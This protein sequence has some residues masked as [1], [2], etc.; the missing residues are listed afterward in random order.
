MTMHPMLSA[1]RRHKAGVTL[2]AMQIALTLA[3]ICNAIFII[4]Q[5]IGYIHQPT[6]MADEQQLF[7][8][9]QQW[10][11]A[12]S[13][14]DP[15][16]L[17]KLDSMQRADLAALRMLP[18]VASVTS[19]NALPM[20]GSGSNG[21]V[22]LKPL[23]DNCPLSWN[24]YYGDEQALSTMGLKLIAGRNFTAGEV[25]RSA[26]LN[27]PVVSF[28]IISQS[29]A[30][31]LFPQGDAVGKVVYKYDSSVPI[32]IV[33]VVARLQ[34]ARNLGDQDGAWDSALF[35]T[36][37]DYNATRYAVRAKPGRLEAAM[38]AVSP[39]L[40]AMNPQRV[41]ADD[42]VRAFTDFR[43]EAYRA[44]I[45]MAALMGGVCVILLA[46]TALGI[47][48]M[49]NFWVGERY[50]QI[51]VRRALG[52]RKV[53]ILRYFQIENL[54]I[55]GAG[56][57]IGLVMAVALNLVLMRYYEMQ[58]L[59]V[60]YVL[61][62]IVAVLALGQAAVFVPARRASLVPPVAATRSA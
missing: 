37:L 32:T 31:K 16:G 57:L 15:D 41:I 60:P 8:V 19:I 49:S 58:R 30:N 54:L 40:F 23:Q 25:Q 44:D 42:G 51:G 39:A 47:V 36:R 56:T 10:V 7:L 5:R 34:S 3:I 21:S 59:P 14:A 61:V 48:G 6:G 55:A 18:D 53:D 33:G 52:A 45:G 12:P 17:E 43:A 26:N 22:C 62:G 50:R 9:D 20:A 35:S 24:R 4:G 29:L 46:V 13:G 1:L 11:G 38:K 27:A 2:I 28:A